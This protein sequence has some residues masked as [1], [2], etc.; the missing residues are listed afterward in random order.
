MANVLKNGWLHK[1]SS[2]VFPQWQRRLVDL[3]ATARGACELNLPG[4]VAWAARSALTLS[5]RSRQG[6]R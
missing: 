5:A 1:R 3:Q 4:H 6:R 2:S